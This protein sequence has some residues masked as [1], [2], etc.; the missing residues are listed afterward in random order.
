MTDPRPSEPMG[1]PQTSASLREPLTQA[2]LLLTFT[3]GLVDA[4]S[5]IGIGRV[6]TANMTG[7][8]ALLGFGLAGSAH[9]PVL[10][11]LVSL[12][13][14]LA[15]AGGGGALAVRMGTRRRDHIGAAIAIEIVLILAAT[16]IAAV[17]R[18]HVGAPGAL[19]VIALLA[20]AMGVRNATMRHV[21]VADLT[22]TV[23]TGTLSNLAAGLPLFGGSG[24]ATAR[25]LLTVL[26]LLLGALSGALLLQV[27]LV[28]AMAAAVALAAASWLVL[29]R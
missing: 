25:R 9:L 2:L 15:G 19:A 10:A 3:T 5:F 14:F 1:D 13:A 11:P 29:V 17:V 23:L 7:N 26:A 28:L 18:I 4:V 27:T 24:E 20:L 21:G 12:V 22:T 6:F 16:V 8:V